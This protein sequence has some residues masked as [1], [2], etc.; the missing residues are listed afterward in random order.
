MQAKLIKSYLLCH[1]LIDDHSDAVEV[2]LRQ[3]FSSQ[4][5]LGS[6]VAAQLSH[7]VRRIIRVD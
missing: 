1:H 4:Q 5:D 2:A 6:R 7:C 3:H